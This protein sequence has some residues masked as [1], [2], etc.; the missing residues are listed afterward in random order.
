MCNPNG[1]SDGRGFGM[2]NDIIT[3]VSF[4]YVA[5]RQFLVTQA[6]LEV[7]VSVAQAGLELSY[8]AQ[9][10]LEHSVLLALSAKDW[11]S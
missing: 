11:D 1:S 7:T 4:F 10:H 6:G 2:W 9:G 5:L 8:V 3:L